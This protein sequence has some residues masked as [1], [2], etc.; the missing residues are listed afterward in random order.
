M[1]SGNDQRGYPCRSE[2]VAKFPNE[3]GTEITEVQFGNFMSSQNTPNI[4]TASKR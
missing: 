2:G 4:Y 3:K 1:Y